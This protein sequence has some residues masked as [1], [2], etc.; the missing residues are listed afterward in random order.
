MVLEDRVALDLE[1]AETVLIPLLDQDLQARLTRLRVDDQRVGDDL[2]VQVAAGAVQAREALDEV[3][4]VTPLVVGAGA[5]PEEET[6]ETSEEPADTTSYTII[7]VPKNIDF[8]IRF[9][10]NQSKKANFY[11][12]FPC[13]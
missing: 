7:P 8:V 9:V 11:S 13:K 2:E 5:E 3:R 1:R 6:E 4:L 10:V 12:L